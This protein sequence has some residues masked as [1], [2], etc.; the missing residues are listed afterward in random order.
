VQR[1]QAELTRGLGLAPLTADDAIMRA[2]SQSPLAELTVSVDASFVTSSNVITYCGAHASRWI[3]F[4]RAQASTLCQRPRPGPDVLRSCG[5]G[6]VSLGA[7]E[8]QLPVP[9]R[10]QPHCNLCDALMLSTTPMSGSCVASSSAAGLQQQLLCR[11]LCPSVPRQ[12]PA[13]HQMLDSRS[14]PGTHLC[15]GELVVQL[16]RLQRP[17]DLGR[18]GGHHAGDPLPQQ[19]AIR[20][21][22]SDAHICLRTGGR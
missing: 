5:T 11:H 8:M 22:R 9:Q 6:L 12:A 3:R 10:A 13:M 1:Q 4:C 15:E 17:A 18:V 14:I 16:Q 19:A 2:A 21:P 7:R 20:R